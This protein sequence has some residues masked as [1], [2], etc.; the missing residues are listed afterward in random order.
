MTGKRNYLVR[1]EFSECVE[2]REALGNAA[3]LLAM[4]STGY[5]L[6]AT[7]RIPAGSHRSSKHGPSGETVLRDIWDQ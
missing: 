1:R 3:P 6:D 4:A 5:C 7:Q 2:W